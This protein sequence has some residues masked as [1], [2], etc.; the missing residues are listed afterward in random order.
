MKDIRDMRD[1]EGLG[2]LIREMRRE[3]PDKTAA[4]RADMIVAGV[5]RYIPPLTLQE[6]ETLKYKA[7]LR[8]RADEGDVDA[9]D[10]LGEEPRPLHTP[11]SKEFMSRARQTLARRLQSFEDPDPGDADDHPA[12]RK[13]LD[14]GEDG[15]WIGQDG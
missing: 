5:K 2:N 15:P 11:A 9:L 6:Q 1:P 3:Y 4:Q 14:M 7:E 13:P 10:L 8:S 12:D